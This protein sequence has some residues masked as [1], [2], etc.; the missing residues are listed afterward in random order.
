MLDEILHA[1]SDERRRRILQF[2]RAEEHTAGAIADLFP[3]VTRP[4]VSQHLGVLRDADLVTV[5]REGTRRYY[6]LNPRAFDELQ[7]YLQAFWQDRLSRL[8][9][10]VERDQGRRRGS[11]E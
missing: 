5:R 6:R 2:V 9:E 7:S 11:H 10:N 4:A 3:D 8:K 1:L